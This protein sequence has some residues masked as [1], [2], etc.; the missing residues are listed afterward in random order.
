MDRLGDVLMRQRGFS[1]GN[2]GLFV[3]LRG[4]LT[5]ESKCC[6]MP[7]DE[8]EP[9][10]DIARIERELSVKHYLNMDQVAEVV[11]NARLQVGDVSE[12]QLVFALSYYYRN[13]A[14]LDLTPRK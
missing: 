6:V 13:D 7:L 8:Y 10:E 14:F 9:D 12:R 1:E 11:E 2:Q 5:Q 4:F 3:N